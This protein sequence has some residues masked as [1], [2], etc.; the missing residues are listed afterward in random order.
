[1]VLIGRPGDPGESPNPAT[2]GSIDGRRKR[3]ADFQSTHHSGAAKR[4]W[5]V[6][7][8]NLLSF[9]AQN[10][11]P[12]KRSACCSG[13]AA[14]RSRT[15]SGKRARGIRR[16]PVATP[17]SARARHSRGEDRTGS[18]GIRANHVPHRNLPGGRISIT[19]AAELHGLRRRA[20]IQTQPRCHAEQ[21][22]P[23]VAVHFTLSFQ[24]KP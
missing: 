2:T 3:D 7:Q 14:S 19:M 17:E 16:R 10:F 13:H 6:D 23:V 4:M 9:S 18:R 5:A 11:S 20:P 22:R 24:W 15:M 21:G 1:M 8:P 12:V